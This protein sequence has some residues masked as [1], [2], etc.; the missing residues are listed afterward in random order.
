MQRRLPAIILTAQSLSSFG[1]SVSTIALSFMVFRLTGSVLQ[2][3]GV[4]A[5]ST[6]PLAATSLFGG[7]LLDRFRSKNLMIVADVFRAGLILVMPF[8]AGQS[9]AFI[10]LVAAAM[11]FFSALFNPAQIKLIG[12]NVEPC[13]LV[14]VDSWLSV[15]R[16]G[17][18]LI[19]YLSGALLVTALGYTS[20]FVLDSLTYLISA[21]MLFAL[22]TTAGKR[23]P[24]AEKLGWARQWP[25]VI[26]SIWRSPT[27]RTNMLLVTFAAMAIMLSVPN[28]AALS[29]VL[30][31]RG[32]WGLAAQEIFISSGMIIGG[33]MIS[34]TGLKGDKNGYVAFSLV[35]MGVCFLLIGLSPLFWV[36]IA[37][38]GLSGMAN[39]L[40]FV[41]SMTLFQEL[42]NDS[43]KG[44]L[45]S[46]RSGFG[47]VGATT[48]LLLG[49]GM[50]AAIGIRNAFLV[51]GVLGIG[52]TLLFYIPYRSS[53][54]R[55]RKIAWDQAINAGASRAEARLA[56]ISALSATVG[57]RYTPDVPASDGGLSSEL[58][59]ASAA[60][61]EET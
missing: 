25:D 2:Y 14:R 29:L 41:P 58:N 44:R 8:L 56:A 1:T 15:S 59:P 48:G 28:E 50:G 26:S 30:F 24:T 27:L 35:A 55:G 6:F 7:V 34:K 3:G 60:K 57:V 46:I 53:L 43:R 9:V 39:V 51:A 61:T 49:G 19:G 32:A 40:T 10:Y 37:L 12:E 23:E 38:L 18:E 5:A 54:E 21:L 42:P 36:S 31:S 17:A 11:G 45:I 13:H 33:L 20:T 47:Q 16:D 4:M 52:L 22:V